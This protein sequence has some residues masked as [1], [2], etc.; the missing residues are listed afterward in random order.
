M[1]G[2]GEDFVRIVNG[3][4]WQ[5]DRIYTILWVT[6]GKIPW[7]FA[8]SRTVMNRL[9]GIVR[10]EVS[11]TAGAVPGY[12]KYD[13]SQNVTVWAVRVP[14]YETVSSPLIEEVYD[15]GVQ[16]FRSLNSP[17]YTLFEMVETYYLESTGKTHS[18]PFAIYTEMRSGAFDDPIGLG[19]DRGIGKQIEDVLKPV[20]TVLTWG[21]VAV[22]G[23]GLFRVYQFV[24]QQTKG[25]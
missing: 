1:R 20:K 17:L 16:F 22:V 3:G 21:L 25:G 4:V 12:P 15:K 7:L 13:E 5:G 18:L 24:D 10:A 23:F 11:P 14:V 6:R 9:V 19:S 2:R 8:D